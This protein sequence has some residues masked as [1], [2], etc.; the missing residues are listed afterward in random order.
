M[1]FRQVPRQHHADL[2]G[3]DFLALVV[4]DAAAV[5]VAVEAERDIRAC[6]LHRRRHRV[7]HV[8]VLG[9]RIVTRK[10]EIELAIEGHDLAAERAQQ[11]R[12]ERARRAV[13]A[14]GDD[15]QLAP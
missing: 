11:R 5:A 4:D 1:Q 7:Q 12:R 15:F 9:I 6:L 2:V 10:S 14:G 13:A 3:E 8:Q